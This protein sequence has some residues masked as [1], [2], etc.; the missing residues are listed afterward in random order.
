MFN[1]RSIFA[2]GLM[3]GVV[4]M[5]VVAGAEDNDS[6]WWPRWGMGRMMM[7]QWGMGGPMVAMI[8]TR[9]SI[10]STDASPSSRR[11]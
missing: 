11:N 7:G 8:Q 4:A 10:G 3:L 9:C 2:A 5:P 6:G 1:L